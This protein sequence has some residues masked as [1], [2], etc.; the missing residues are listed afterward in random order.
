MRL[1]FHTSSFCP[2]LNDFC[3][4]PLF[5]VTLI[6]GVRQL[7]DDFERAS[8]AELGGLRSVAPQAAAAAVSSICYS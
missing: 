3:P 6:V 2:P 8:E 1:S 7:Q 4:T 5:A